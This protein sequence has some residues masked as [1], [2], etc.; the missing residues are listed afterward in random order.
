MR[1]KKILIIDDEKTFT[2]VL[3]ISLEAL[4]KYIVYVENDSS[5]AVATACKFRP[6]LILLD[7]I[8]P[9][10]EG[11]DVAIEFKNHPFLKQIPIVF[12]T[13]NIRPEEID[14]QNNRIAGHIFIAKPTP[15]EDLV[16]TIDRNI[17][18]SVSL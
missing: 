14:E 3:K 11:P 18:Q 8:M 2:V 17:H 9:Y 12:L 5:R 10:K 7:I 4:A 1:Q 6:D 15:F 16:Q 13:A